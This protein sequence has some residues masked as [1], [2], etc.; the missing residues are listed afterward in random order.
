MK[1]IN[2]L[3]EW[4]T[5]H[6]HARKTRRSKDVESPR[7]DTLASHISSGNPSSVYFIDIGKTILKSIWKHKG[8]RRA[9]TVLKRN[10]TGGTG[11]LHLRPM[12]CW[13]RKSSRFSRG[14]ERPRAGPRCCDPLPSDAGEQST[15]WEGHTF[16]QT[17]PEPLDI[18]CERN[19]SKQLNENTL[20]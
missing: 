2:H 4:E 11:M 16:Q 7:I 17:V 13:W 14:G 19:E 6:A 1:E 8:T 15:S 10:K 20:T 12:C 9:K 3:N 5:H 18:L